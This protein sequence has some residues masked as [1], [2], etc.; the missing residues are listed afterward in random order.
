MAEDDQAGET[1]DENPDPDT[2]Q[3]T[4]DDER[5]GNPGNQ[6]SADDPERDAEPDPGSDRGDEAGRESAEQPTRK[7]AKKRAKK[8][9]KKSAEQG[10][11]KGD[12]GSAP[13][14][15]APRGRPKPLELARQATEQLHG[16]T[17]KEPESTTGIERTDDG[18]RIEI[19]VVET[20]RIPDSADILA[21]YEVL[22]DADGELL[23]YRRLR[24][25]PRGRTDP[26]GGGG[27]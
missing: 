18:W 2:D 12:A 24:R 5:D 23:A 20:R 19:E 3:T 8:G 16:L 10:A 9:A 27:R 22:V 15:Q 7:V 1:P 21:L 25:Y 13:R 14:A 4:V 17:G 11:R 6:G 26:S